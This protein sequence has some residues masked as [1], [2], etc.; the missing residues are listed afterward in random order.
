MDIP[1][2]NGM[3]NTDDNRVP[4]NGD[5]YPARIAGWLAEIK[6]FEPGIKELP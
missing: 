5:L 3:T 4:Q 1:S 6:V 2:P